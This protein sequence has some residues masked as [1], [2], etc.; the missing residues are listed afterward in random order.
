MPSHRR[1]L[2]TSLVILFLAG[3][4]S[5]RARADGPDGLPYVPV[6]TSLLAGKAIGRLHDH[7]TVHPTFS[8][9]GRYAAFSRVVVM[10]KTEYAEAGY[11]DLDTGKATVLMGADASREFA[12]YGAFIYR[13]QWLDNRRVEY[14]VSDGD[15]D[16]SLVTYDVTSNKQVALRHM[17]ADEDVPGKEEQAAASRF[18]AAF[19]GLAPHLAGILQQG[20]RLPRDR[21]VFQKNY[22][23]QDNHVW[24]IDGQDRSHRVLLRLPDAGWHFA[25]RGAVA[26][27]S[28]IVLVVA[29]GNSVYLVQADSSGTRVIDR[30]TTANDH[31]VWARQ[32]GGTRDVYFTVHTGNI[33]D[34]APAFLYRWNE[35]GVQ[36]LKTTRRIVEVDVSADGGRAALVSWEGKRRVVDILRI[37]AH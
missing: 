7:D 4:L 30:T 3:V 35:Q 36:R 21:W 31:D 32:L 23:G 37:S 22:A 12:V 5:A 15:V 8:P 18:G 20:T 28:A 27:G 16:S 10:G 24:I 33:R 1:V 6:K 17:S 13:I 25:F 29:H 2:A 11:L 26:R 14:R 34:R 19:P 9:N